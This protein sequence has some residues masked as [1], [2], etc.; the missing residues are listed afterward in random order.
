MSRSKRIK[1]TRRTARRLIQ[2]FRSCATPGKSIAAHRAPPGACALLA[3]EHRERLEHHDRHDH[4]RDDD[5]E[6]EEG[7]AERPLLAGALAA[8]DRL[9]GFLPERLLELRE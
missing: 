5:R 2:L 1:T 3:G 4:S 6:R 9:G 7:E 8:H